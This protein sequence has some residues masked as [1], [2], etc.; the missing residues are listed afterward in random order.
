MAVSQTGSV[1][2]AAEALSV[3]QSAISHSLKGLEAQLGF[4]L[5]RREGRGVRL[6]ERAR[7]YVADIGPALDVLKRA[8]Q[9]QTLSGALTLNVASGFAANWLAPRLGGFMAKHPGIALRVNTPRGYGDLGTRRN[10]L[11]I[12]FLLPQEVPA[13]ATKLMEVSFFPVAAPAMVRQDWQ[14][15]LVAAGTDTQPDPGIVFQ[16]LQIMDM[17]ARSGQGV[18]LGDQMTSRAALDRGDL[19][20]VHATQMPSPRAYWLVPGLGPQNAPQKAFEA[21]LLAQL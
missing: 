2:G 15:W 1:T 19:M 4:P 12:S 3:T 7:H 14:R 13:G 21:W 11:Y 6:T 9:T 5:L 20:Q 17:A 16:D 10:D 18:A 8:S